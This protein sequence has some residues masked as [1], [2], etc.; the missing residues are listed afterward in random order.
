MKSYGNAQMLDLMREAVNIGAHGEVWHHEHMLWAQ[1]AGFQGHKRLNRCESCKDREYYISIQNYCIDMFDEVVA[2]DWNYTVSTSVDLKSYLEAYLEW[3]N[4]VY[5]RLSEI[6]NSLVMMGY[7]CEADLVRE[8][9]PRKEIE[10][11]R[12]MLTEYAISGWDMTYILLKDRE[13]H[14]KIKADEE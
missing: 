5:T 8:G 9:L 10:R 11:V 3:E 7:P 2:P 1:A 4:S 6:S 12:R 13:L 14:N